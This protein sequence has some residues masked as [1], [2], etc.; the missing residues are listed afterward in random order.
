MKTEKKKAGRPRKE[1]EPVVTVL[2]EAEAELVKA[3]TVIVI[4]HFEPVEVISSNT[5]SL[6]PKNN[7]KQD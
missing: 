1:K 4:C 7:S 5:E 3:K 6:K 2:N